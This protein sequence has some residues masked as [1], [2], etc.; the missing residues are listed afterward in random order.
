MTRLD[1][2]TPP[3]SEADLVPTLQRASAAAVAVVVEL[4]V[5]AGANTLH[6]ER[7]E[8]VLT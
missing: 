7:I 8:G 6:L 2:E 3:K 4:T 1:C 5:E